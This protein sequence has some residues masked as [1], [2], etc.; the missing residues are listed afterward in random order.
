MS[1]EEVGKK[2]G[3][4]TVLKVV[5]A[6]HR[7]RRK[8]LCRCECGTE[9][10]VRASDVV[11]GKSVQCAA[12]SQRERRKKQGCVTREEQITLAKKE[13]NTPS[14]PRLLHGCDELSPH[15]SRKW[16]WSG[17]DYL[18]RMQDYGR[19]VSTCGTR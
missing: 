15:K 3:R 9:R 16:K 6:T 1:E 8:F 13:W 19:K 4:W 5:P 12:C 18:Q 2:Y 11:A 7:G 10:L 17:R 14:F